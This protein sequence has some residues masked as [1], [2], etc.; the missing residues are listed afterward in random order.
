MTVIQLDPPLNIVTPLGKAM[1]TFVETEE[2]EVY[3]CS[4]QKETGEC[5]WW[6]NQYIRMY[7]NI[8]SDFSKPTAIKMPDRMEE[9]LRPH[10]NRYSNNEKA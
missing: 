6:R 7:A 9:A 5:W 1:A 3:W 4:F 2:W 8:T 10:R